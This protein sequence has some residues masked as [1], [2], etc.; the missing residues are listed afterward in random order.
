MSIYSYPKPAW[1]IYHHELSG[2]CW[3]TAGSCC[4]MRLPLPAAVSVFYY[5]YP[6]PPIYPHPTH[7]TALHALV[8]VLERRSVPAQL[9]DLRKATQAEASRVRM[10]A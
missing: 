7:P 4:C 9:L 5:C 3:K 8:Y 6:N 2:G 1:V 10:E